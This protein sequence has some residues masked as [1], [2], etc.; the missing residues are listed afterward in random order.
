MAK[1]L[2]FVLAVLVASSLGD[3][4][5][6]ELL[7]EDSECSKG[8]EDECALHALQRRALARQLPGLEGLPDDD[9]D[10]PDEADEDEDSKEDSDDDDDDVQDSQ[11]ETTSI[12]WSKYTGPTMPPL[13]ENP[14][15]PQPTSVKSVN[16]VV[17][18]GNLLYDSVTGKR[19]FAKGV[20]YNPR[21][22][23]YDH[24]FG[25]SVTPSYLESHPKWKDTCVPG[26]P[27]GGTWSYTEDVQA[28]VHEETWSRDL[29]AIANLGA[30]TV[31]LYNVDPKN[32]HSKFMKRAEELGIYIIVPLNGKDFGFLPAFPSPDCY[33]K[34]L[35][36]YGNVGVHAL[37]FSKAIVKEFSQ[38]P[39]TLLFTVANELAQNDKNGFA[40]FPCVKALTRDI[41][42]YQKSCNSTMRRVP[43]I[44][45]DV[46]MG[47]PDRSD[48]AKYLTCA[49][50]SEDDAVDAYG[51]NVYSWCDE[52]YPGDGKPDNFK[53]SPYYE[54]KK[55][56]DH[57][58]VPLIFT[59]FG[60]NLGAF[61]TKCPYKGGRTWP[62]FKHMVGDDM[63]E[64]LSGAVAFQ[65]SM[66]RE[67]YG[68]TL[69]A[70][71]LANQ[72]ELYLLDN[73][74]NLQKVYNKYHAKSD[75]DAGDDIS[76]CSFKPDDVHRL[77][78]SHAQPEC[79]SKSVWTKLQKRHGLPRIGDWSII[80]ATPNVTT[81][82]AEC[83]AKS[84]SAAVKKENCCHM[85]C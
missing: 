3:I 54:I 58:S 20:A 66:D 64:M 39:N 28:D 12:P 72:T 34:E 74:F 1:V 84:V 29:E 35:P 16:P 48:I 43:L 19:F 69:S 9:S 61:A 37:E 31:R 77:E 59:E 53:Y 68:L 36:G 17:T 45:S 40:A 41:H 21:N 26:N 85:K 32:S 50:E 15:T 6:S 73:Y 22:E 60:C 10:L 79:P 33:T 4:A 42:Q 8:Q 2:F 83:P 71:F 30:N 18:R 44:Y 51:L 13:P 80:P 81:G 78:K 75:W 27:I 5:S 47:P 76:S 67:E 23:K 11:A 56:F 70:N 49:L 25:P 57:L 24:S 65:F 63:G 55:G 62:D 82:Q 38:Y 46:D 7:L 52:V 14:P